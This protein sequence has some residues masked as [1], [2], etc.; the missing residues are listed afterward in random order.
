MGKPYL[1]KRET[2]LDDELI[3]EPEIQAD[4]TANGVKWFLLFATKEHWRYNS[5]I[6][7][8]EEGLKWI[9]SNYKKE[10]IK[11]I[12]LPALGCGLGNLDWKDIGPLMCH[13]L[14]QLDIEVR[15]YLPREKDIPKEF[16]SSEY[17]LK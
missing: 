9:L 12:A 16:L 15:I 6:K 4:A 2:S 14:A 11:S 7:G 13:Y 1:Y 10:A 17:L 5:N 8:I 3:D